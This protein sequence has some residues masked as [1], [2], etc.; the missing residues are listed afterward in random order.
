M[1]QCS[2]DPAFARRHDLD[3]LRGWAMLLGLVLHLAMMFLPQRVWPVVDR[4][5]VAWSGWLVSLVH[6]FRMPLFFLLSG[7]FTAMLWRKRGLAAL[8]WHRVR[9]I[10]LPLVLGVVF[11]VP[12]FFVAVAYAQHVVKQQN[13]AALEQGEPVDLLTAATAGDVA[14]VQRALDEGA[15]PIGPPTMRPLVVAAVHGHHEVVDTLLE[16]GVDPN[17]QTNDGGTALLA[18][19]F[20]GR[21]EVV[22]RLLEAGADPTLA[23]ERGETPA[24]VML[25]D[26]KTTLAIAKLIQTQVVWKDVLAGRA[27]IGPLLADAM[28]DAF[29]RTNE[30]TEDPAAAMGTDNA[31]TN[32]AKTDDAKTDDAAG[33]EIAEAKTPEA[34]PSGDFLTW[35]LFAH[36]WF[37]YHL[38]V[39]VV[40]FVPYALL[41]HA[42]GTTLTSG[43]ARFLLVGWGRLLW[44]LPLTAWLATLDANEAFGPS[45][46]VSLA[47]PWSLLGYYAVFFFYGAMLWDAAPAATAAGERPVGAWWPASLV[48]AGLVGVVGVGL[49]QQLPAVVAAI[50]EQWHSRTEIACEVAYAWLM[51]FGLMG[52]F[53]RFFAGESD[54]LRFLSDSSYFLYVV[55]MPLVLVI[56]AHTRTWPLP[57]VVK[58]TLTTLLLTGGL[59]LVY[60]YAVRYTPLGTL[61][62]GRRVRPGRQPAAD[63]PVDELAGAEILLE[64]EPSDGEPSGESPSAVTP[65]AAAEPP[66]R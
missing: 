15:D 48:V 34:A 8:V 37:L 17:V 13:A 65:L 53:S 35:P 54:R 12:A 32:D 47:V 16:A 46:T 2:D 51:T 39:F 49:N 43:P 64:D 44:L 29:Q 22:E 28:A 26:E 5:P 19:A 60:R 33:E 4:E 1:T 30:R 6:G 23:N 24:V 59:L 56:Q 7:F 9:R 38:M 14:A 45:T 40:A 31:S 20:L 55:H 11:I 25:A 66:R 41:L 57:P 21:A 18:A 42:T 52:A 63:Q 27:K 50:P 3:A 10:L 61:L 36:L 58:L 62:N